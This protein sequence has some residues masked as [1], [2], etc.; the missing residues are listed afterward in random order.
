M[1]F[2]RLLVVT[3]LVLALVGLTTWWDGTPEPISEPEQIVDLPSAGSAEGLSST[4]FCAGSTTGVSGTE[5]QLLVTNPGA[6]TQIRLGAYNAEG[7]LRSET[8]EVATGTSTLDTRTI[9]QAVELSVMV[10]SAAGD[11]VVEHRLVTSL[12]VDQVPCATSASDE[13]HFPALTTS[14][15]ATA[16]LV[17]FNPFSADAGVDVTVARDDGVSLPPALTGV[18]VPAGTSKV[19][20]LGESVQRRELFALSLRLRTGRVVAETIQVYDPQAVREGAPPARGVRMMLGVP[21][22]ASDWAFADGF[23]GAGVRERVVVYNPGEDKVTVLIQ[24][25]P[26][27][28]AELA[29]EPFELEVAPRR[30]GSVDLSAE[31][32]IPGEGLH[33][34]RVQ[35]EPSDRVVVGRSVLIDGRPGDATTPGVVQRPNLEWGA[36]IS[37]GSPV[38]S[39]G[40]LASGLVVGE[41]QQPMLQIHNPNPGI[42]SFSAAILGGADDGL[43]L[44]DGVEVAAGDTLAL[45]VAAEGLPAGEVTVAVEAGA[46]VVVERLITFTSRQ[47]LAMGLAVPFPVEGGRTVSL[48]EG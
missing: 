28:G 42:V 47:D 41:N 10:E 3:A 34:I 24:V 36:T 23:T 31:G 29:P 44:A 26:F 33:A 46:P 17:L 4:W 15:G 20:D 12:G 16:R 37:G 25:T 30:Y 40:W 14:L 39:M 32:R 45:P 35:S 48:A 2:S 22:P 6:P 38:A 8:V 13:W 5:H 9:F 19:I 27:S 7:L 1:K 18:V 11:L 43:V 21:R